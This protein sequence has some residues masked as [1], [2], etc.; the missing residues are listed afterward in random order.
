MYL[1]VVQILPYV[2][3]PLAGPEELSEEDM[4]G[5]PDELQYLPDDKTR[6]ADAKLRL[7]L[8]ETLT[9]VCVIALPELSRRKV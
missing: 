2:L 7:M 4:E 8:I 1:F 3:L 5:M 6:E 9:Q